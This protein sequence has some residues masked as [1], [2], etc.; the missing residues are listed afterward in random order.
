M[1]TIGFPGLGIEPFNLNPIAFTIPVF[2]GLSISWYGIIVTLS[3]LA[4]IFY[5][6]WRAK[7]SEDISSDDMMDIAIFSIPAAIIGARAYYVILNKYA[8]IKI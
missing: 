8:S 6:F 7:K 1:N 4:G 2:G 3:I 5:S